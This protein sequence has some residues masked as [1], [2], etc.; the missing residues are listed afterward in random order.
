[1]HGLPNYHT[2]AETV[3]WGQKILK[4]LAPNWEKVLGMGDSVQVCCGDT[5]GTD[6]FK[7][8]KGASKWPLASLSASGDLSLSLP[9]SGC[10]HLPGS[11]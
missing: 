9:P 5:V 7:P 4:D 11:S 2:L 6:S 10:S 1:M 3:V 8:L